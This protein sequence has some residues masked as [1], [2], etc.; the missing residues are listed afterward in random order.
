MLRVVPEGDT[1]FRLAAR[2]EH[3]IGGH[4]IE[5]CESAIVEVRA[6]HVKGARVV[7]VEAR[8]KHLLIGLSTGFTLH[9]H[10][11]MEGAVHLYPRTPESAKQ[12]RLCR[13]RL[14]TS[15]AIVTF[16]RVPTLRLVTTA[17]LDRDPTLRA[18]GP[19]P[20]AEGFD[21]E[22]AARRLSARGPTELAV[23]L[24]DQ[25]CMAGVGNVLKSEALFI[26]RLDPFAEVGA[27]PVEEVRRLVEIAAELLR[28]NTRAS[29]GP[30]RPRFALPKRVTRITSGALTGR[31]QGLWVY[32]R[33]GQPCLVCGEKIE[34]SEQWG[35][36]TYHCPS[37]QRRRELVDPRP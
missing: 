35:R 36:S 28:L 9:A 37:C 33:G 15:E 24:L 12:K 7:R 13:L 25:R 27:L 6:A 19:D 29:P 18:L 22:E 2:L 30:G 8:G 34:R 14:D 3:A 31:G 17:K 21:P 20:L 26:A 23:A 5:A 32:E 1:I 10:L 11:R 16:V 4:T